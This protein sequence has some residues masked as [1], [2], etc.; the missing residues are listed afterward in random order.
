MTG[1]CSKQPSFYV[2]TVNGPSG[3]WQLFST[4]EFQIRSWA[5][6]FHQLSHAPWFTAVGGSR[7]GGIAFT[8]SASEINTSWNA[9][10]F[11]S[12]AFMTNLHCQRFPLSGIHER[13]NRLANMRGQTLPGDNQIMQSC[14]RTS[15]DF[16]HRLPL[17]D[18]GALP[19]C[20]RQFVSLS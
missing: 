17:A 15:V 9:V 10:R 14:I 19:E 4:V 20:C 8:S 12:G 6:S 11:G 13:K 7:Y 3:I 1:C 16:R 2:V 5:D 18:F